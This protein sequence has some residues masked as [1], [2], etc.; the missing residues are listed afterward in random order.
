M[1]TIHITAV[2]IAYSPASGNSKGLTPQTRNDFDKVH[3]LTGNHIPK[4]L[5]IQ[6]E[7]FEVPIQSYIQVV[8]WATRK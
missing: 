1:R 3:L 8:K 4:G 2:D 5:N 6:W 7:A